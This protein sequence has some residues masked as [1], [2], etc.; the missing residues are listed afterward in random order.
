[1]PVAPVAI[2][3]FVLVGKTRTARGQGTAELIPLAKAQP[4]K[5][6]YGTDGIGTSMHVTAR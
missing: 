5:L 3:P 2:S 4:G 1:M 6:N